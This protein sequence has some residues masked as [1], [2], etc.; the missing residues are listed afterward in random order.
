[1]YFL[2]EDNLSIFFYS[3]LFT[4][5]IYLLNIILLLILNSLLSD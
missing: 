5:L 1:M 4:D 2:A 3:L